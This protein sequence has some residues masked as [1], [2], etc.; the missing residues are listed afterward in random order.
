MDLLK[1]LFVNMGVLLG[2]TSMTSFR[3]KVGKRTDVWKD[4]TPLITQYNADGTVA[5]DPRT[6]G[7]IGE[8]LYTTAYGDEDVQYFENVFPNDVLELRDFGITPDT[9]DCSP[10]WEALSN[11]FPLSLPQ[12]FLLQPGRLYKFAT[13]LRVDS[14][15]HRI[16]S[17]NPRKP[18][19]VLVPGGVIAF[20][21]YGTNGTL[22]A[23]LEN[24]KLGVYGPLAVDGAK[25]GNGVL[26]PLNDV[27]SDDPYAS[28]Y[29]GALISNVVKMRN[30][31]INGFSGCGL[32]VIAYI[33]PND[34]YTANASLSTFHSIKVTGCRGDGILL[35]G[36]DANH[37][38][39]FDVDCRDN[40]GF[41]YTDDSL[42][43]NH[44]HF[45]HF[46]NNKRGTFRV[47]GP[48]NSA[49][50][51]AIYTEEQYIPIT[52]PSSEGVATGKGYGG[53]LYGNAKMVGGTTNLPSGSGTPGSPVFC[54]DRA[55][56]TVGRYS[57][58]MTFGGTV[59]VGSNGLYFDGGFTLSR[60][61]EAAGFRY[62]LGGS[63]TAN[64]GEFTGANLRL[65]QT[66]R[67]M[68]DD[69]ANF[70]QPHING[71]RLI[72]VDTYERLRLYQ[73]GP[74]PYVFYPGDTVTRTYPLPWLPTRLV[75]VAGGKFLS[76]YTTQLTLTAEALG[77]GE[78]VQRVSGTGT[79]PKAGDFI[80]GNGNGPVQVASV[81]ETN[82]ILRFAT[83]G[84]EMPG[85]TNALGY[86]KPVFRPEGAGSGTSAQ[87]PDLTG[88]AGPWQYFN[89]TSGNLQTW[90]GAAWQ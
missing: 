84:Y 70:T 55:E 90:T 15:A 65:S 20:Q 77:S 21:S 3:P 14:R 52:H 64:M 80:T 83:N 41:G 28:K 81:D 67:L 86:A 51:T 89:T 76:D 46:N 48:G 78:Y 22:G 73:P 59:D 66:G 24:M 25:D 1:K 49:L 40:E 61:N 56:A 30:V 68:V 10:L 34:T 12:D 32:C 88:Y 87:R 9:P 31:E 43:G 29:H 57:S 11:Y 62:K 60:A 69:S 37:M 27:R 85:T 75:C 63:Y 4:G 8:V 2:Q 58:G 16:F 74:E 82:R 33:N 35:N 47:R 39:F 53:Y 17:P 13:G 36:A 19:S 72:Q 50:L 7:P 5:P 45:M 38:L 79:L 18:A 44:A 71:C 23:M 6:Q 42:L 26:Y 54:F